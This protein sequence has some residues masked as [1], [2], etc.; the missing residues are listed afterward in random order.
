MATVH[1]NNMQDAVVLYRQ[2]EARLEAKE[3]KHK[4]E[5]AGDLR[6]ME[7]LELGMMKMLRT[8]GVGSMNIPGIAEVKIVNKRTFGC[9]DWNLF[10]TWLVTNN[11]P[12]L[13]QQRIH[14]GNM[15][16]WIDEQQKLIDQ[17]L[18]DARTTLPPAVNVFTKAVIKI[19]KGK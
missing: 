5:I 9:G 14:E 1:V 3:E 12:E 2:I 16:A 10:Q 19:L 11:K 13:L 17:G 7:Q 6:A 4:Q 18:A 15:Q 8:Q